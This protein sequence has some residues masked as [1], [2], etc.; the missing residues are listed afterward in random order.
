MTLLKLRTREDLLAVRF[1]VSPLWETQAAV[2]A[3]A[4][5]RGRLYHERWLRLVRARAS[6]LEVAPLLAVLPRHGYVPDF[7]TPPPPVARPSLRGELAEI[8]ATDPAQVARELARCRDSVNDETYRALITSLLTDPEH[9]RD[10]LA[11]RLQEAWAS[12]VAPSWIRIRTLLDRDIEQRSRILA[13]HGL[14]RV[15]DELHPKIRWTNRGL[16]LADRNRRSVDVGE[17]GFLL[18]PSAFLWPHAAA[19]IE[20]PWL[21]T[22]IYPATGIAGLWQASPAPSGELER[23]LGRTRARILT[24]LDQPLS[25]T[26]LAALAGLSPAG[27]SRHLLVL[28]DAGLLST[29]RHGHEVHYHRTELG[30]ALFHARGG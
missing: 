17:R 9:A 7:L 12:L 14:R 18:M 22:I 30:S 29:T 28:R 23:L 5:E 20:E 3:L 15:L 27:A 19:I 13:R 24:T 4:D 16:S 11:A 8:R 1:A 25:T 10:K 26:A 21:P 2:Q 6:R